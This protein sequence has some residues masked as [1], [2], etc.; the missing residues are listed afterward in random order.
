MVKLVAIVSSNRRSLT[1][2]GP[3]NSY[4]EPATVERIAIGYT[5]M[6]ILSIVYPLG[7]GWIYVLSDGVPSVGQRLMI[8]TAGRGPPVDQAAINK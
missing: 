4:S 2:T 6:R 1:A 3:P 5:D 8:G 7:P